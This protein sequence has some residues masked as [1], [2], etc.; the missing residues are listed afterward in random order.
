MVAE[1]STVNFKGTVLMAAVFLS[2]VIYY[3]FVDLPAEQKEKNAKDQ[4]E[5]LVPIDVK[6]VVEFSLTNNVTPITL[7]R[8]TLSTWDL[9]DP[10]LASGDSTEVEAFI[11]EIEN[12]KKIRVVEENPEDLSIYGLNSPYRKI[13]FKFKNKQE[14]IL[15][16]GNETPMG[17]SIYFKRE[18]HPAVMMAASSHSR[19]EKSVYN[20]RDKTLLNFSSGSIKHIEILRDKNPLK[21]KKI[22]EV[23]EILGDTHNR[24]DKDFIISFLQSIQ[25]SQVQEFIDEKPISL[26]SYGLNPPKLKLILESDKMHTL[27][28]GN[29]HEERG[30]FARINDSKNILLVETQLFETLSKKNVTFL[31][32]TLLEFEEKEIL[33]L[34]L[35]SE[36]ETIR[37]LHNENNSW[38]IQSP[39]KAAADLSTIKSLLFD[40]K[41]AKI[42]D[43]INI[44][45]DIPDSFGLGTPLKTFSIKMK[46][47]KT[48]TLQLGN[49]SAD[50]QQVFARRA[51]E[52]IVFSISKKII[53]K[54]FR[55]LHD[56]RNKKL[57]KFVNDEVNRILIQTPTQLFELTKK[58]PQWVLEKPEK[59]KT[60]HIGNDLIWALKELEFNSTITQPLPM[61]L[62]GLNTP[63]FTVRL[64]KNNHQEVST[65]KVGKFFD[66]EQEYLVET[67]GLQYRVKNKF[68]DSIPLSLDK[69]KFN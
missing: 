27:S 22:D 17:G 58:G 31:D 14:E 3:F 4:A 43:F 42:D 16:V 56:L 44:S 48:W 33:E 49:L 30:Y 62:S 45:L 15:L 68:L 53:D 20:F 57:L 52:K 13:Y 55:H 19:F 38:D 9:I 28:L 24:A 7:K 5:K 8:K 1:A 18:N 60:K 65:L 29:R 32:K 69:F 66:S 64:F 41:G 46:D 11:S 39:I 59:I 50:G 12:L 36:S 10:F 25:F 34:E 67:G 51:G 40:L 35:R 47:S 6:N 54:L 37:V 23:W 2:L 21:L 61:D 26:K 63:T